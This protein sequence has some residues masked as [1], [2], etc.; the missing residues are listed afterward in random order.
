[1]DSSNECI[2]AL[3]E[4]YTTRS[5]TS[6]GLACHGRVRLYTGKD[7]RQ[8]GFAHDV[9]PCYRHSSRQSDESLRCAAVFSNSEC[10]GRLRPCPQRLNEVLDDLSIGLFVQK[11]QRG[12]R[13][14][15]RRSE[16]P[17]LH[18][19]AK[20]CIQVGVDRRGIQLR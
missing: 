13:I 5:R 20:T 15:A 9:S 4:G 19:P 12:H 17:A 7:A 3:K 16:S 1:M 8:R 6:R 14:Y 10:A 2:F 18:L 11:A